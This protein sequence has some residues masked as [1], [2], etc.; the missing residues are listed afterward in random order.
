MKKASERWV[1]ANDSPQHLCVTG[2]ATG[3]VISAYAGVKGDSVTCLRES[4]EID[5]PDMEGPRQR[6][7]NKIAGETLQPPG[8]A[9]FVLYGNI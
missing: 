3:R 2:C 5:G 6:G 4:V 7:E 9:G 1:L 8:G